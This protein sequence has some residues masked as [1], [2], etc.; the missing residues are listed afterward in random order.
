M[1]PP[2]DAGPM[3]RLTSRA[4]NWKATRPPGSF[5]TAACW[6]TV[7]LP[8]RVPIVEGEPCSCDVDVGLVEDRGVL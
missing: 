6:A 3:T 5:R 1:E 7:Q 8:E 4:W 2:L